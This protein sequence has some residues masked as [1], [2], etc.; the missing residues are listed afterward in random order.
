[1]T[2]NELD[3]RLADKVNKNMIIYKCL[4]IFTFNSVQCTINTIV[5]VIDHNALIFNQF[6]VK[7]LNCQSCAI[8]H[9]TK[10]T[11]DVI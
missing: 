3:F 1:M 6:C 5:D 11:E 2:C 9:Q 10:Y 8:G 7:Y 4:L